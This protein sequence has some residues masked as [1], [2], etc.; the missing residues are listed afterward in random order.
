MFSIATK[1]F[2]N[3]WAG[4]PLRQ[5]HASSAGQWHGSGGVC[6]QGWGWRGSLMRAR[7]GEGQKVWAG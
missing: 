7:L 3:V 6:P 5:A 4:P 1:V 2:G